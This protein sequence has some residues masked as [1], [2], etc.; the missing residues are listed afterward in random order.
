MLHLAELRRTRGDIQAA[1]AQALLKLREHPHFIGSVLPYASALLATGMEPGAVVSELERHMPDPSPAARFML[2]TALYGAG[3]G[4]AGKEQFMCVLEC[5]SSSAEVLSRE[6]VPLL[7]AM[8][9]ALLRV[10]D[11][12]GFE[13]LLGLLERTPLRERERRELLAEMY[14]RRGFMASAAQEWMAVCQQEP[15]VPALLGLARVA[16]VRGMPREASEFTAAAQGMSHS[17][18]ILQVSARRVDDGIE[19]KRE[20]AHGLD[21]VTRFQGENAI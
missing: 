10:Q 9:E 6:A 11:F 12:H 16:S 1:I 17:E 3:A 14:M 19:R 21:R 2:G 20:A 15:D 5:A 18:E 8:L 13:T 7:A 4:D